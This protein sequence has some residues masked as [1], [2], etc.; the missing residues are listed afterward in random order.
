MTYQFTSPQLI[1]LSSRLTTASSTENYAPVYQYIYDCIT[2]SG[3][4][5]TPAAGVDSSVW[6]WVAGAKG[7]NANDGSYFSDYI[8]DWTTAEYRLR[9]GNSMPASG[10]GSVQDASNRIA[11]AFANDI[12]NLGTI[13]NPNNYLPS[14]ERHGYA[15]CRFGCRGDFWKQLL[16]LG[17]YY[18]LRLSR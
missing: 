1:E 8:R 12:L 5:D 2:I 17:G 6:E 10:A 4:Y 16:A 3:L 11:L 13:P 9:N 18:P 14:L 15:R 7:V